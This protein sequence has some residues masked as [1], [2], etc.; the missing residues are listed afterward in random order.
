MNFDKIKNAADDASKTFKKLSEGRE[1]LAV[2]L[3]K[4]LTAV[5]EEIEEDLPDDTQLRDVFFPWLVGKAYG[6]TAAAARA[7]PLKG[8]PRP[9]KTPR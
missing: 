9:S 1:E 4:D 3:R 2:R 5:Y 7:P 6:T 8:K